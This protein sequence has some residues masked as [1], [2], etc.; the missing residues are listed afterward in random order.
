MLEDIVQQQN[1]R[2]M[3]AGLACLPQQVNK[4]CKKRK[5]FL[6]HFI[7]CFDSSK[8]CESPKIL[9]VKYC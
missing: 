3:V 2:G 7:S 5:L 1:F 6:H 8:V 9:S 4:A